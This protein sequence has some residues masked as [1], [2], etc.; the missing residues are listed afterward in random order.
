[1]SQAPKSFREFA[2]ECKARQRDYIRE[3]RE[4]MEKAQI[5]WEKSARDFEQLG[6]H[7]MTIRDI[8]DRNIELDKSTAEIDEKFGDNQ[9]MR[10][11][12]LLYLNSIAPPENSDID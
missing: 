7:P 5:I 3:E 2:L 6:L 11:S 1:M 10:S 12:Y 9:T 8:S 4:R